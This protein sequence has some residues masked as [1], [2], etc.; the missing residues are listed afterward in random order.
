MLQSHRAN[1]HQIHTQKPAPSTLNA[2]A[3]FLF[4]ER[5]IAWGRMMIYGFDFDGTLVQSWT[6][7]PLPQ[8][9]EQLAALPRG[10]PTFVASNQGG[11]AFRAVLGDA[12]YPTV[13]DVVDRLR[14]GFRAL[15]WRPDLLLVC[16][17]AG[18]NGA[19]LAR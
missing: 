1:G 8:A 2:R 17:C 13:A 18:R 3:G 4:A 16:C 19:L 10:A 6:A 5:I 11:P 9:R 14:D 12:K 7:T 15:L